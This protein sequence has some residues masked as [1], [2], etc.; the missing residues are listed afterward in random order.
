MITTFVVQGYGVE[1][2]SMEN[3][4]MTG[5]YV[6]ANKFI[7]GSKTPHYIPFT[8]VRIPILQLP[9]IRNPQRGDIVVFDWP[10]NRDEVHP[11]KP[12]NYFK[13]CVGIP[14]DTIAI[15]NRVL[16][17]NGK[18]VPY[19]QDGKF[20]PFPLFPKG[21]PSAAI[22]PEGSS[23]NE[24]NYGPV[25]V[26]KKGD[27]IRLSADDFLAWKI[28]IEREGHQCNLVGNTVYL[29][30]EATIV[31]WSWNPKIPIYDLPDR[32]ASI[33]WNRIGLILH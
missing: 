25:V 24:D 3:T 6:F 18:Y 32:L 15:V 23:F 9:P 7:Y 19:P 1:S 4:V 5:D 12:W 29:D 31:Y 11:S 21:Y 17:V 10:G 27:V 13:R 2:G 22:F 26:P 8:N 33:K 30:G 14:G 28:F 16:Y 20:E